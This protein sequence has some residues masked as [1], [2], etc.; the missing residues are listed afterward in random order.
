M[1]GDIP[2][3]VVFLGAILLGILIIG[4]SY[5]L[6]QWNGESQYS[7]PSVPPSATASLPSPQVTATPL[8]SPTPTARAE[9]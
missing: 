2:P 3:N 9:E 6:Y 5:S 4:I 8:P 7:F 1:K